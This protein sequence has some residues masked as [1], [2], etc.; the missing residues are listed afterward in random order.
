MHL[1]T[2]YVPRLPISISHHESAVVT[3]DK[4]DQETL[5]AMANNW[6]FFDAGAATAQATPPP[7]RGMKTA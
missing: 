1:L 6:R 7:W 4:P 5:S 3:I 2:M